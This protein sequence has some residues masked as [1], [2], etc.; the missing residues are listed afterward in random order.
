VQ[1]LRI[2]RGERR[3]IAF[4]AAAR[5]DGLQRRE[6]VFGVKLME[7]FVGRDDHLVYRS[8]TFG[9]AGAAGAAA[10]AGSGSTDGP[11]A[12]ASS[13]GLL[14]S[15]LL[16]SA[17]GY[18]LPNGQPSG[19]S[20]QQQQQAERALPVVKV[21][22]RFARDAAKPADVDVARQV[23]HLAA[24]TTLVQFHHADDRLTADHLVFHRD[25]PAQA[26]QVRVAAAVTN[27]R[28]RWPPAQR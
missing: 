19:A 3:E 14:G 6:E 26:V 2:V 8:L 1:E 24:G 21:T 10:A 12:S 7:H 27:A 4:Y 22:Q 5:L 15:Q 20:Q 28:S 9:A 16:Q 23:F 13:A 25:G 17:A 11:A 18:G